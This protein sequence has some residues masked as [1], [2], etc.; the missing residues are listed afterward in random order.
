MTYV[1][2]N[3]TAEDEM[4]AIT[5]LATS[6]QDWIE[7]IKTSLLV[8]KFVFFFFSIRNLMIALIRHS[9]DL[10]F[11]RLAINLYTN[12]FRIRN[13]IIIITACGRPV[14]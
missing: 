11:N 3:F 5:F 10:F 7:G 14:E 9:S 4:E 2:I 1:Y 6:V 12:L 13:L 8:F